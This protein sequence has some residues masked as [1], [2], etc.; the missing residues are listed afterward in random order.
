MQQKHNHIYIKLNNG[1]VLIYNDIRRFG[2]FKL[3]N[4]KKLNKIIFLR[5]LGLEPFNKKFNIKYF[6]KFVKNRKKNIKNL[7][8]DQTFVSGLGNIYVNEALFISMIKPLRTCSSL[9][10]NEIK[11]LILNVKRILK[12][13]ISKG[14]SSIKDFKNTFGKSGNFQQFFH[15]YGQKNKKCSRISC[16]GKIK[17]IVISNR[18]TF[19]CNK[20]Q[21]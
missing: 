9:N 5:K 7:L 13:A 21:N 14:G 8:M 4:T 15:V 10:K 20:C 6:K 17:K 1:L 12:F 11:K 3:Y 19:Y 18:S 16:A 2:F